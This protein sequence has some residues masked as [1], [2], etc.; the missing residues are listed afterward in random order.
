MRYQPQGRL[1]ISNA[2]PLAVG[3]RLAS[4]PGVTREFDA[5][6]GRMGSSAGIKQIGC[7][8]GVAG[9]FSTAGHGAGDRI[10][11]PLSGPFP[12]SG[13]SYYVRALRK[14]AGGNSLGRLFDKTS[15]TSGQMLYWNN[16]TSTFR[17]QTYTSDTSTNAN[18]DQIVDIAGSATTSGEFFDLF[19]THADDGAVMAYFNGA[20]LVS[21]VMPGTLK[22]NDGALA[23]GN[24]ATDTLR[25]W[26][27]L[28]ES[29]FIWDRVL[30]AEEIAKFRSNPWHLFADPD[31]DDDILSASAGDPSGTLV[32]TLAGAACAMSGNV[33]NAGTFSATLADVAMSASGSA[34]A[35]PSG[36]FSTSLSD[37]S[38]SASGALLNAGAFSSTLAGASAA[39]AGNVS[40]AVTGTIGTTLAGATMT[41]SDA[42]TQG[43]GEFIFR[44]RPRTSRR[45]R[46]HF[47]N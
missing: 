15:G 16:S 24:R 44:Y 43:P 42:V 8:H 9:G 18:G 47:T 25:V 28:I 33:L 7:A 13:R 21:K 11:T 40:Q 14:G 5:A 32:A 27:G 46:R 6:T 20:L 35:S 39:L 17:Y 3:M 19:V 26:D 29:A 12:T 2:S 10:I 31:E 45:L 36:S 41:A 23:I 34:S 22:A 4:L 1:A 37:V 30:S 38:F